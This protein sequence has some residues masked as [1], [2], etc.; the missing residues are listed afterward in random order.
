MRHSWHQCS[1]H[2][3]KRTAAATSDQGAVFDPA[4]PAGVDHPLVLGQ[5]VAHGSAIKSI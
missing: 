1:W 2:L 3:L 4:T 5:R